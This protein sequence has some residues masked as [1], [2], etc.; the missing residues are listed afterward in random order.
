MALFSQRNNDP[1]KQRLRTDKSIADQLG[2]DPQ[3]L[4]SPAE[5][6][7]I[8]VMR[9]QHSR[10]VKSTEDA[11]KNLED[12]EKGNTRAHAAKTKYA[13]TYVSEQSQRLDLSAV[14]QIRQIAAGT[15]QAREQKTVRETGGV[16]KR[17]FG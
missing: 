13:G 8:E 14:H 3:S 17:Y 1:Q 11:F 15:H 6:A 10:Y 12:M 4:I 7:R 16:L 5:A 2:L 9:D